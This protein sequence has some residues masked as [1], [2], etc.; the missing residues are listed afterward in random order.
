MFA[1]EKHFINV[2]RPQ[3][4]SSSPSA[5][6]PSSSP[7]PLHSLSSFVSISSP[8]CSLSRFHSFPAFSFRIFLSILTL[9]LPPRLSLSSS[10]FFFLSSFMDLLFVRFCFPSADLFLFSTTCGARIFPRLCS[11]GLVSERTCFV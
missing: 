9:F 4:S 7:L 3:P 5:S 1:A 8:T 11:V 6:P 2:I 10:F